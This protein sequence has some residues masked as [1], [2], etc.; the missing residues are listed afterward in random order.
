MQ[1]Y[2]E[3]KTKQNA[4][5]KTVREF[6]TKTKKGWVNLWKTLKQVICRSC[7]AIT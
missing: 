3:N 6:L 4:K 5:I 2:W 7:K 1:K